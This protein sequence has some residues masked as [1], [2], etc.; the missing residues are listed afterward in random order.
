MLTHSQNNKYSLGLCDSFSEQQIQFRFMRLILR[1]TSTVW[2]YATHFTELQ[3]QFEP[4]I[5]FVSI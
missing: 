5:M 2:V 1:T 3:I 4:M